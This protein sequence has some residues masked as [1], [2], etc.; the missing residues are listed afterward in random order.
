MLTL[1]V[2]G[3]GEKLDLPHSS[4]ALLPKFEAGKP[5]GESG[6]N[7]GFTASLPGDAKMLPAQD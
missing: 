3:R 1:G 6:K 4:F 7:A 2:L 5:G